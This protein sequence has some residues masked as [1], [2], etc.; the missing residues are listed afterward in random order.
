SKTIFAKKRSSHESP[1]WSFAP[2]CANHRSS[3]KALFAAPSLARKA[4][5]DSRP[6]AY[7]ATVLA[8]AAG[9]QLFRGNLLLE[10]FRSCRDREETPRGLPAALRPLSRALSQDARYE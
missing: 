10:R 2:S 9:L 5:I 3:K 6:S 4:Q 1:T 8:L 7:G